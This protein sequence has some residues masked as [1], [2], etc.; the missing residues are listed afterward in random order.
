MAVSEFKF[1]MDNG[2]ITYVRAENR[3][4]AIELFC[5]EQG[6]SKE[7]A[8]EHCKIKNMGRVNNG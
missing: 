6:I 5:K 1:V 4:A 7:F 8:K 2:R 3:K